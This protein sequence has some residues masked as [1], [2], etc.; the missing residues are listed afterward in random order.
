MSEEEKA[1]LLDAE[2]SYLAGKDD[3]QLSWRIEALIM[4]ASALRE[5]AALKARVKAL[6]TECRRAQACGAIMWPT[7]ALDQDIHDGLKRV[8]KGTL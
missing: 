7:C 4:G 8:L 2:A 3:R 5:R 1:Q 6:E